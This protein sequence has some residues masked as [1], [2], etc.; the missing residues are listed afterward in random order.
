ALGQGYPTRPI[1]L[2]LPYT[3]GSTTD[4]STR[5]MAK[6]MDARLNQSVLVENRPGANALV[7]ALSVLRA[8]ADG[9]TLLLTNPSSLSKVFF[10][11]PGFD[12][13]TDFVPLS[14]VCVSAF[15]L[16]VHSS[17]PNQSVADFVK[18]AKANPGKLN[19][20]NSAN[21]T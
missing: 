18:Y 11:N 17:V 7:G 2:I 15:V 5:S 4:A 3:A 1:Q 13:K 12:V 9:Y 20:G 8:P 19:Y 10:K 21:S 16:A 6:H 14:G